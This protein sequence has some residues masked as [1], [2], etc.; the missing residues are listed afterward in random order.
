MADNRAEVDINMD[1]ATLYRE[2][3]IT[4]RRVGTVQRLTPID[5]QGNQDAKRPVLYVGQISLRKDSTT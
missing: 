1:V 2:E 4:D 5:A 3:T